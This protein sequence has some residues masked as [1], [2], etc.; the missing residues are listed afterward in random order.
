MLQINWT[1]R[2]C[3]GIKYDG[4]IE[5]EHNMELPK[6][7]YLD[8]WRI[9]TVILSD[10]NGSDAKVYA[11]NYPERFVFVLRDQDAL[12][13]LTN[14]MKDEDI[15]PGANIILSLGMEFFTYQGLNPDG[16]P[17]IQCA[18]PDLVYV[19]DDE[20]EEAANYLNKFG[21]RSSDGTES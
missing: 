14:W 13:A 4:L 17:F 20:D 1:Y 18:D 3:H 16:A 19:G 21:E 5:I 2:S 15:A 12:V 10:V 8:S 7:V 6:A 11:A 9:A